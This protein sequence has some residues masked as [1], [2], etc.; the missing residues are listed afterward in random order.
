ME[1]AEALGLA[2]DEPTWAIAR[3]LVD[4]ALDW[5]WDE[6]NGG[7]YDKGDSFAAQAYD[8]TKVW[9]TEAEGLDA[10]LVMDHKYGGKTDRYVRSL[11]Q[12]VGLYPDAHDRPH[13][14]RLVFRNSA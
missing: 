8:T 4:H 5:G 12:A 3:R 2:D 1:A 7:F 14:R 6:Q 9:W 11:P 10:L 13:P